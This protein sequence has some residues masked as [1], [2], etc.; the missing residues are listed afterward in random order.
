LD[1]LGTPISLSSHQHS[2][3]LL[4][5]RYDCSSPGSAGSAAG[6][7]SPNTRAV[8]V[9]LTVRSSQGNVHTLDVPLPMTT[10]LPAPFRYG[11]AAYCALAFGD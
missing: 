7:A 2:T 5:G 6:S 8:T 4:W 1:F 9:R 11:R 10:Q 3:L